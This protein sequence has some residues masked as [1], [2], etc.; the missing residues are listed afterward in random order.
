MKKILA[1][2]LACILALQMTAC[3]FI[4]ELWDAME[5]GLAENAYKVPIILIHGRDS[6]TS[7]FY[8]VHTGIDKGT[9]SCY[10]TEDDD[11]TLYTNPV[12]HKIKTVDE[13]K[14][15]KYLMDELG[16]ETNVNLFAFNY[17]NEDMVA[18]NADLL[19]QYIQNLVL[20]GQIFEDGRRLFASDDDRENG[21]VKFILI[22]HSMGG[23]ISRYYIENS[24]SQ[25][26][27][28]LITIDS[29]HYGSSM[30]KW[31]DNLDKLF[32]ACDVDLRWDS[33]LFGGKRRTVMLDAPEERH[34][35][36]NQ[37]SPLKGNQNIDVP[38]YAI[39]G[40]AI[41][42]DPLAGPLEKH[43]NDGGAFRV[44]F[45]RKTESKEAFQKS[46]NDALNAASM[47]QFG[48]PSTLDLSDI[49]GDNVVDYMSQF[50]VNYDG[51]AK[52]QNLEKT[53]LILSDD[54][55][56]SMLHITIAEVTLMHEAVKDFITD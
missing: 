34:G 47:A 55:V 14:L 1:V 36:L 6:N 24:D 19:A 27:E 40:Y 26:V 18:R 23:L 20:A 52:S 5:G 13:G 42:G 4:S 39:G 17:P 32:L 33:W 21:Q 29:P 28:K 46:I 8:G 30:S 35:Y 15:G 7:V 25:Y 54:K 22:G 50:A 41:D 49:D 53:V 11:K 31:A 9:N 56:F 38:Y 51:E 3:S 45:D 44:D 37:S 2:F 10:L 12:N 16:Y 48:E 43:I